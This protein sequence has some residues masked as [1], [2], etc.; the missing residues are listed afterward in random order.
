MA[1]GS[2]QVSKRTRQGTRQLDRLN[3][4]DHETTTT[5]TIRVGRV[6]SE[7][8]NREEESLTVHMPG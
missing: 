2:L 3:Q 4:A 5:T 1:P 6:K 7:P 8:A